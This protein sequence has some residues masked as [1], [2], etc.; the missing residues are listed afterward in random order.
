[1]WT[2]RALLA[3]GLAGTAS[4]AYGFGIE[5]YAG[6]ALTRYRLMPPGW[7][8]G[9]RLR[10]AALADLH[11]GAPAMT[12][13]RLSAIVAATNAAA[14][15]VVV[16]LGDYGP[17]TRLVRQP[18]SHAQVVAVLGGLRAPQGRYAVPGN[19]DWWQDQAAMARRGGRLA[20]M[21]ALEGVGFTPLRNRALRHPSG[22]WLAG[23][24]SQIAFARLPH[25]TRRGWRCSCPATRMAD[26]S[27]WWAGRP[28]C[29]RASA[30]A[31][32]MGMCA[33]VAG[34]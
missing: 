25:R 8:S 20:W 27:G 30:I 19:H 26:R 16:L 32:P 15:D 11:A 22:F 14:P 6:P 31:M 1:M 23:L 21:D 13:D 10:V 34:T 29:P 17:T 7:P 24:D 28:A 4:A 12:L 2:R 9:L 5:P 3:A 18:Y 33:R